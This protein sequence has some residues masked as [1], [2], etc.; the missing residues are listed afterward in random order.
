MFMFIL[1]FASCF[2][3]WYTVEPGVGYIPS[4]QG[5]TILLEFQS[6]LG[7]FE[8][9]SI[10]ESPIIL[11]SLCFEWLVHATMYGFKNW[12][13]LCGFPESSF[14]IFSFVISK[15][16]SMHLCCVLTM[17]QMFFSNYV[18]PPFST[19]IYWVMM[20]VTSYS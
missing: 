17:P 5:W 11:C 3:I 13:I 20:Y 19:S 6:S 8:L 16:K 4:M 2:M 7:C 15:L 10:V 14:E 9:L 12:G 1:M 18:H